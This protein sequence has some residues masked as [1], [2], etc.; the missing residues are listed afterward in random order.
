[1]RRRGEQLAV[2]VLLLQL[3]LLRVLALTAGVG[4]RAWTEAAHVRDRAAQGAHTHSS[5]AMQSALHRLH[6]LR[7]HGRWLVLVAV[8]VYRRHC[9]GPGRLS[10]PRPWSLSG[11]PGRR[12]LH[13]RKGQGLIAAHS[14][15]PRPRT[16]GL[17]LHGVCNGS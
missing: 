1:M 13:T 2:H 9:N 5:S 11:C 4:A 15:R 16:R 8:R 10:R 12:G 3:D 6:V 17:Q 14:S 7:L